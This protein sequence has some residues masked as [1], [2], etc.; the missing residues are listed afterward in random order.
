MAVTDIEAVEA[1]RA[2]EIAFVRSAAEEPLPP[3]VT[4]AGAIGWVRG[5]L[6]STPFNI[7]L[8]LISILLILWIVPPL[9]KFLF[10]DAVWSGTNRDACILTA[11]RPV[12]GACWPF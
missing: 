2:A 9:I 8:T 12:V 5:N 7:V 4:M 6:I 11:E 10:I 1:R 3:P